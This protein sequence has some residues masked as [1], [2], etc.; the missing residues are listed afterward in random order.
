ML[1]S[2]KHGLIGRR[3][4]F[5]YPPAHEISQSYFLNNMAYS[6]GLSPAKKYKE[7][8]CRSAELTFHEGVEWC[9]GNVRCNINLGIN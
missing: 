8:S 9:A 1:V 7:Q 6:R 5:E 2:Y 4:S 3:S